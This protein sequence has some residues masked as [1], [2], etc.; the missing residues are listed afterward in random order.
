MK[1]KLISVLI[2][3][4]AVPAFAGRESGGGDVACEDRIKVIRDDITQWIKDGGPN[5]L[6]LATGW[7]AETYSSQMLGKIQS[8]KVKCV[9]AGDR[10]YPVKI[11]N[12]P[13]V[14][15]FDRSDS[16]DRITCDFMKFGATVESDQYVQMHHEYAGLAGIEL[17]NA[18]DSNYQISNQ[19]SGF[20]EE[21]IIKKLAVHKPQ[22][23]GW[24]FLARR[25]CE[26]ARVLRSVTCSGQASINGHL[27]NFQVHFAREL[28][29]QNLDAADVCRMAG[30]PE[31]G[32]HLTVTDSYFDLQ[33]AEAYSRFSLKVGV[34]QDRILDSISTGGVED[35]T[36][37]HFTYAG[38]PPSLGEILFS[39]T[40][41]QLKASLNLTLREG[42]LV[43][44]GNGE[45]EIP[46]YKVLPD[47]V[48]RETLNCSN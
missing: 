15:R 10:G 42:E 25:G 29:R 11:G 13:K 3:L 34:D 36:L 12:T 45:N 44:R 17:P 20:L 14:C 8:A 2:L 30:K 41:G 6:R 28:F 40:S 18:E 22:S 35:L 27:L 19:I 1:T 23:T 37:D 21:Q 9:G 46:V 4:S 24:N 39:T 47:L 7:T 5:G 32:F 48:V 31:T 16:V 38:M 26:V 33:T 43:Q